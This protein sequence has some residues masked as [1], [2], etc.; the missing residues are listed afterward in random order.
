MTLVLFFRIFAEQLISMTT[1]IQNRKAT[2][3]YHI[4]DKYLAGIKL[5]GTEVKSIK[6]ANASISEA[7]CHIINGE[8]YLMGMHVSEYKQIKHTNHTPVRDRKLLLNKKEINKLEKSLNEKGLTIIP[9]AI[10]L[11]DTGFIKIE[12]GVAKGK[13]SFDKRNSIKEKDLKRELSNNQ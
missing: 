13:K 7:Y 3:E 2:Y 9:L 11:S 10:K 12:I 6:G 5:I 1:I 4:L 8:L